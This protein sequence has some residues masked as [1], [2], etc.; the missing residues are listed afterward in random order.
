MSTPLN[1]AQTT[2]EDDVVFLCVY[3]STTK[4][5]DNAACPDEKISQQK[6]RN[7]SKAVLGTTSEENLS[8]RKERAPSVVV[9]GTP[10]KSRCASS[11]GSPD[12]N[13]LIVT[14][15]RP[16]DT[17]NFPHPRSACPHHPFS[18]ADSILRGPY[19]Q[20]ESCCDKCYCYV[21]D[22]PAKECG[23]WGDSWRAHCNAYRKNSVWQRVRN[24]YNEL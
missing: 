15:S 10:Q 8:H 17:V 24:V 9:L 1:I 20:N 7:S 21:C 19:M 4:N 12:P 18:T 13:G 11:A 6:E 2:E 5:L 22:K 3:K 23:W 14:Y 16:A